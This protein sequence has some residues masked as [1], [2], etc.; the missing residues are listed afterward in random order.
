MDAVRADLFLPVDQELFDDSETDVYDAHAGIIA[1]I[2]ARDP[3]RAAAA[4]RAHVERVRTLV[5]Q[6]LEACRIPA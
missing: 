6:A 5:R 1:A 2:R 3:Q 4:S